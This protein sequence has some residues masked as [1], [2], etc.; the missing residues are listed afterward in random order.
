MVPITITLGT[1]AISGLAILDSGADVTIASFDAVAPLGVEWDKLPPGQ[2]GIG[3]GATPFERRLCRATVTFA[4]WQVCE[5]IEVAAPGTLGMVL[6]GRDFFAKFVV[7]FNWHTNAPTFD[8][9]PV[10]EPKPRH[11]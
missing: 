8:L 11:R 6:L 7:R 9:D 4:R 10:A 2:M 5:D 3:A 1:R